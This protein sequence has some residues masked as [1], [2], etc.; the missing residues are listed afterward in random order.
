MAKP[1]LCR[2]G[3]AQI[4]VN[5]AYADE[6]VSWT[7]E[8]FFPGENEKVGLFAIGGLDEITRLRQSIAEQYVE[9]LNCK[10]DTIARF[11]AEKGVELLI[12]P[13]YSIPAECL[14][15]CQ[16][17]AEELKIALVAGS[18][19]LTLNPT[20]QRVYRDLDLGFGEEKS[21]DIAEKVRQAICTTFVPGLK[22]IAFVKYVR[23]KWEACLRPGDPAF[24][25]FQMTT[26]AGRIE[27]EVMIC[28]EALSTEQPKEKHHMP[29]LIVI[30]AFTPTCEPFYDVAKGALLQGKCTMLAN[31]AEFGG[32][33]AFARTDRTNL[34][35]TEKNGSKEVPQG[36][37]ALLL[38]EAD[39]EKQFEVRQSVKEFTAVT[40]VRLFPIL[41]PLDS[42]DAQQF[43]EVAEGGAASLSLEEIHDR[44]APF[45]SLAPR[46]FPRLLQEKLQQFI[47]HIA[48]SGTM[49][50]H[51]AAEWITPITVRETCSSDALRWE[52]CNQAMQAVNGLLV[53]GKYAYKAKELMEVYSHLV[54]K[55]NELMGRIQ[56]REKLA[57]R[58]EQPEISV[59]PS[60]TQ[61]PFVDRANAFDRI[62]QFMNQQQQA[63]FV[64]G[65]MRGIGKTALVYEAFR[66]AIPPRKKIWLQLT[67][68]ISYSR[69]LAEL[70][71][72]CNLQIPEDLDLSS[73][74]VQDDMKRRIILYLAQGPGIVLVL[75]EFQFLLSPSGEVEDPSVRQFLSTLFE[76]GRKG[77]I[78]CFLTSHISP[79]LGPGIES[80][81]DSYTLQ[82]LQPRDTERLLIHW[83]QFSREDLS[84]QL[85]V[86]S[87]RLVSVL[88]GHPLA[89]KVAARLWAEHPSVDIA[90]EVSIFKELRDTIVAFI[91]E[92]LSL[93]PPEAELLSFASI[94]RL[95]VPR[96]VFVRW[97]GET[98]SFLLNSLTA[99]YLVECSAEGYQLHPLVRNFYFSSLSSE[100]AT[101]F[102]KVAARFFQ[103]EFDR[104]KKSSRQIMPEYL[105]EAIHHFLAAGERQ[106]VEGLAFYKQELK[107]VA[108]EHYRRGDF[109]AAQR[110]YRVLVELDKTDVDA[111]FHLA[112]IHA[113]QKRWGDAEYHFGQAIALRPRAHWI[114]HGYGA[115]KIRAG[116]MAEGEELLL[117]AERI[118]PNYSPTMCD[119]GRL[120]EKQGDIG[121]AEAYYG[122]AIEADA[123]NSLAYYR[124]AGLLYRQGDMTGAYEMAMAA[125]TTNPTNARNKALVQELRTK[126]EEQS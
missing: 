46:V 54:A 18:H 120:R 95:P 106:R 61:S 112:L 62:R 68:G 10:I 44:V 88:G 94:F 1:F 28:I 119:L 96:E 71:F 60:G 91:L 20:A 76:A 19:V 110:D 51:E 57:R 101:E 42:L 102:H 114:F 40:D 73:S 109:K 45:V 126:I 100:R 33:K 74:P 37:E 115:A 104:I 9:H 117:E 14:L 50:P 38:I 55:R 81:C 78:K 2:L 48:P 85:P 6:L 113:R 32:S 111:H 15:L 90:E 58:A 27:V 56:P 89:V 25:K 17:L 39:L 29:H 26:R 53:D 59:R 22:P 35:F 3:I 41:Y 77:R 105:G 66:Q 103:Q 4:S 83:F 11:A 36:S 98:A 8:P 125:L 80:Q 67:E 72:A 70:A 43:S 7:Q 75:D 65:G 49:S 86:P 79:R 116:Q 93:S 123:N 87:E 69:L 64:L 12:F 92:K 13:E 34:W 31:V 122:Q 24:H 124:L 21:P 118:N 52:L 30:P 16:K 121:A 47:G 107:P 63:A 108:L 82:G 23:S 99:Q 84:A 5:P 97:R